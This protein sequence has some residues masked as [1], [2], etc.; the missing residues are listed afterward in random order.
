MANANGIP[1]VAGIAYAPCVFARY[2]QTYSELVWVA[3]VAPVF[4][5][6][7]SCVLGYSEYD[8]ASKADVTLPTDVSPRGRREPPGAG[9]T[10][11]RPLLIARVLAW[12]ARSTKVVDHARGSQ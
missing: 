1:E 2:S 3:R 12:A 11:P 9:A 6:L 10:S 4:K 7:S 5:G 8:Q